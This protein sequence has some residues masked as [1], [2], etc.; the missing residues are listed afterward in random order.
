MHDGLPE[1]VYKRITD[2]RGGLL[3]NT[4][5]SPIVFRE[6]TILEKISDRAVRQ[7]NHDRPILGCWKFGSVVSISELGYVFM[8]MFILN[9]EYTFREAKVLNDDGAVISILVSA[10]NAWTPESTSFV[11]TD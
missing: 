9:S 8:G 5:G 11:I 4:V 2:S 3:E 6:C 10:N 7:T 1:G